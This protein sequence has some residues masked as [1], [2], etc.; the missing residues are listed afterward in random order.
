MPLWT[1]RQPLDVGESADGQPLDFYWERHYH[2]VE[3]ISRHWRVHLD[4][5]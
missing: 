5:W 2:T 1:Q 4:W 3:H